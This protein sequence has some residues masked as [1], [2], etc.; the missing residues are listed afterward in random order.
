MD[1]LAKMLKKR[2]L[3][4]VT[5]GIMKP[6]RI[7]LVDD[8]ILFRRGIASLLALRQDAIVVGEAC[9]GLEAIAQARELCPDLILMDINMPNCDGPEATRLIKHQMPNV[10]IVMLTA[11]EDDEH[12]FT[13]LENG[14]TGYLLKNLEP[15]QLFAVLERVG[16]G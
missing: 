15:E 1:E 12:I 11:V 16:E 4:E 7:L 13:A 14:A 3:P 2:M 9:D 10:Q 8:H 6:L 5:K